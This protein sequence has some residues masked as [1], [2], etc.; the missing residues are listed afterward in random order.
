MPYHWQDDHHQLD[1]TPHRSLPPGGFAV[2]IGL[3]FILAMVPLFTMLGSPV[4]W[5]LLPFALIALA[6]LWWALRRSYRDGMILERLSITGDD[7]TL[8]RDGPRNQHH[9]WRC[10]RYW[11][12]LQV[13]ETG[14]RVPHY[15][16]LS[17]NGREVEIGAFL[18][19]DER[20]AL[21][22]E[23]RAVLSRPI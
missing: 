18:S 10:N 21:Y 13:H 7:C 17:G 6:A 22:P 3:F 20:K 4:L 5:G 12:R 11:V 2:V 14:G 16:T 19:E 23:L 15:I 1:L 9:E 8:L